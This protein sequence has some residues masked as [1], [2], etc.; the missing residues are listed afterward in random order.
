MLP[1]ARPRALSNVVVV[2]VIVSLQ[3]SL[4]VQTFWRQLEEELEGS[5]TL[6]LEEIEE[7]T[8]RADEELL[9]DEEDDELDVITE[10]KEEDVEEL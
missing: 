3:S 1:R 7:V 2:V 5:D 8:L 10:D 4:K 9:K 6:V